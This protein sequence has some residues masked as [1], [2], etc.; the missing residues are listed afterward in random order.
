MAPFITQDR[1]YV[2][3]LLL[4]GTAKAVDTDILWK[5]STGAEL[6][7][8]ALAFIP[9]GVLSQGPSCCGVTKT[10]SKRSV[11]DFC[12]QSVDVGVGRQ[13]EM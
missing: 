11:E 2:A 4:A 6:D 13:L 10:N 8:G 9:I 1:F 5:R 12:K 7:C 3:P